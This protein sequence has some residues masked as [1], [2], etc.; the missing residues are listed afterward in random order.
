[1]PQFSLAEI[2]EHFIIAVKNQTNIVSTKLNLAIDRAFDQPNQKIRFGIKNS[3]ELCWYGEAGY[4]KDYKTGEIFKWGISNIKTEDH[5]KFKTISKEQFELKQ[6]QAEERKQ[7]ADQQKLEANEATAKKAKQY[8]NSYSEANRINTG[9]HQYLT[10]K[11]IIAARNISGIKFTKDKRIVIPVTDIANKIH[12][13]QYIDLEGNKRFLPGGKKQGNFFLITQNDNKNLKQ[14]KELYLAEGFATAVS[15]HQATN[16]PV[17]VCFDAGNIEHVLKNLK[18]VHPDKQFIIAADNDLWGKENTG[19]T[20]AELAA[21]KYNVKMII[22]EF[23]KIA[24][25][26]FKKIYPN[27]NPTDFNDLHKVSGINEVRRQ[28]FDSDH[29]IEHHNHNI[30]VNSSNSANKQINNHLHKEVGFGL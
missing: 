30:G 5:A 8:F 23:N 18:S 20:K 11:N 4:I 29:V 28:I 2:K 25:S 17:A 9:N 12:S 15:I 1:M 21:R 6:Q 7:I 19:R 26:E 3:S 14:E 22:P 10:D 27:K 13:L 24:V 16:K